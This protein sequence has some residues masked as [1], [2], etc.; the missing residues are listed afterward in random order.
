MKKL[1]LIAFA[2]AWA[3]TSCITQ[4]KCFERFPPALSESSDT[5]I[6]YV[7]RLVHDTVKIPGKYLATHD[8][9]PCPELEFYKE[10]SKGGLK[11]T[12]NIHKGVLK[13]TCKADSLELVIESL[14]K[15]KIT[16]INASKTQ[17]VE[18][19]TNVL[20]KFQSFLFVCG[21]LFWIVLLLIIIS[22]L[23]GASADKK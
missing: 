5:T 22:V 2:L 7:D 4:Q 14:T 20:T 11:Q 6:T 18:V 23:I 15:E 10:V 1:T 21:W 8:T 19:K 16:L 13:A 12:I 9:L 17:T 3:L